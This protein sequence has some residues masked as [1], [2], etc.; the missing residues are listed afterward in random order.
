MFINQ[1]NCSCKLKKLSH[2]F[3]DEVVKNTKFNT[4]KTKLNNLDQ[5]IPDATT[6]IHINKKKT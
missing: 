3:D 2:V 1:K 5:K 6:L 4:L